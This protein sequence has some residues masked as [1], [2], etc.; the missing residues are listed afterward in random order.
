MASTPA[1]GGSLLTVS[2]ARGVVGWSRRRA[3]APPSAAARRT[4]VGAAAARPVPA[5]GATSGDG[6]A[7]GRAIPA[8]VSAPSP[9]AGAMAGAAGGA[10]HRGG[11]VGSGVSVALMSRSSPS[12]SSITPTPTRFTRLVHSCPSIPMAMPLVVPLR[13]CAHIHA[14]DLAYVSVYTLLSRSAGAAPSRWR[15][16]Y[17]HGRVRT[18]A[19]MP[20]TPA[21]STGCPR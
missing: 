20:A 6:A 13:S 11:A 1:R 21:A 12:V 8:A 3:A 15:A 16:A 10:A 14:F 2:A 9:G 7:P 19:A 18:A 5:I 4:V 17:T